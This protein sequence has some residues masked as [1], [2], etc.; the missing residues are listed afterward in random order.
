[1]GRAQVGVPP[2]PAHSLPFSPCGR[3]Q[4]TPQLP[5]GFHVSKAHDLFHMNA[6]RGK[7]MEKKAK[8]NHHPSCNKSFQLNME[9]TN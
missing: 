8:K 3:G 6:K 7:I 2:P 4:E 5:T 1:M 9:V